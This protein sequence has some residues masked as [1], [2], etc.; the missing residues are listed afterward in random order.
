MLPVDI[1]KKGDQQIL[2]TISGYNAKSSSQETFD[3]GST[4]NYSSQSTT[5]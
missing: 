2:N 3:D 5:D 4:Y 1:M